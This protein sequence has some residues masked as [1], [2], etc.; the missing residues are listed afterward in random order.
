MTQKILL[1][2]DSP[3]VQ[4]VVEASLKDFDVVGCST[5]KDAEKLLRSEIFSCMIL[6]IELPD[7]DGV[8]FF[9]KLQTDPKFKSIPTIFLTGKGDLSKKLAAFSLGAE[10]FVTKPFEAAELAA[11]VQARIK[12]NQQTRQTGDVTIQDLSLLKDQMKIVIKGANGPSSLSLTAL[13]F[14]ILN[15]LLRNIDRIFE[16]DTIIDEAWGSGVTVVDRTV[17]AHISHLRKKLAP[18]MVTIEA[19]PGVGYKAVVK[20]SRG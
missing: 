18:S 19:I 9:S 3:Q 11:R 8:S 13:E 16:R 5:I 1:V 17:D 14:K 4:I 7:G 20:K 15:L 2:E 6:D 12:K 10:D